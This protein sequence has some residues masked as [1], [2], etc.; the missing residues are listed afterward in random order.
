MLSS[1][2][3][4]PCYDKELSD[5]FLKANNFKYYE[6]SDALVEIPEE[7]VRKGEFTRIFTRTDY[8]TQHC[9]CKDATPC[10]GLDSKKLATHRALLH[11]HYCSHDEQLHGME[12]AFDWNSNSRQADGLEVLG[13][14]N[15]LASG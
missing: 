15:L 6:H 12:P 4:K 7:E 13:G 5:K 1:W 10:L 3:P 8:H 9:I 2:V 14:V 11:P